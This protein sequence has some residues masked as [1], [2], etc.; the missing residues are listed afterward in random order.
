MTQIKFCKFSLIINEIITCMQ[1]VTGCW[2]TDFPELKVYHHKLN[3]STLNFCTEFFLV[4][5]DSAN[6]SQIPCLSVIS[7]QTSYK[8]P[9]PTASSISAA[10]DTCLLS[11][12]YTRPSP[13]A[14]NQVRCLV[15]ATHHPSTLYR[16]GT[17]WAE[18]TSK[19]INI[20]VWN[21]SWARVSSCLRA[22]E[23]TMRPQRG[24]QYY[25]EYLYPFLIRCC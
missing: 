1:Q 14:A 17:D 21:T 9:C 18:Q 25:S 23:Q 22:K 6:F 12:G 16:S 13:Q 20:L 7:V 11:W 2:V 19:E 8:I 10:L 15:W 3:L 24:N 5:R 4:R